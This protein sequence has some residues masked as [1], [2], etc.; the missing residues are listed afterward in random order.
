MTSD[1]TA[2][3]DESLRVRLSLNTQH[4]KD[5]LRKCRAIQSPFL[6]GQKCLEK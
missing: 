4:N 6:V 5:L 3:S 2:K 1:S